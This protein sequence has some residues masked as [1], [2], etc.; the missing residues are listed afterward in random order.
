MEVD[1]FMKKYRFYVFIIICFLFSTALIGCG[2]GGGGGGGGSSSPAPAPAPTPT[3][4]DKG[5]LITITMADGS[6]VAVLAGPTEYPGGNSLNYTANDALDSRNSLVGS[7]LWAGATVVTQDNVDVTKAMIQNAVTA[8]KNNIAADGLF[9]FMFSGHGTSSGDTG[10]ILP[11]DGITDASK[12]ISENELQGWLEEFP[13]GAKKY[14]LLDACY[15]GSFIDKDL[16]LMPDLKP[17]ALKLDRFNPYYPAEKFVKSL[18]G[19]T[20]TYA[21]TAS[22]GTE[23][24]YESD[25]LQNGIFIYYVTQGLGLGAT[26]GPADVNPTDGTITAEKLTV[27]VPPLVAAFKPGQNPQSYDNYAGDMRVK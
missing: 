16:K 23:L 15:S 12:R 14:V 5:A 19:V 21:M 2:G 25:A 18:V 24:S 4:A 17:K 6:A 8:A 11:Y 26:I 3:P 7:A 9:L 1:L 27:Y 10:Y 22:K 20:N 13:A